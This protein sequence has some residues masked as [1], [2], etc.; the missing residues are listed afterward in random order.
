MT[1]LVTFSPKALGR[2]LA[3]SV[4][5][6]QDFYRLKAHDDRHDFTQTQPLLPPHL[7]L[8]VADQV[9]LPERHKLQAA[10]VNVAAQRYDLHT[11]HLLGHG[12]WVALTTV[13]KRLLVAY[14]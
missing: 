7:A 3:L 14:S 2:E 1:E 4:S 8:P 12:V 11:E 5:S 6:S 9:S 10:V 13:P